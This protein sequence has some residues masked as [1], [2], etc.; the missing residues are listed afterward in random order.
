MAEYTQDSAPI[1]VETPLGKDKLLLEA[2]HGT[3]ALGRLF[4]FELDM[5][6]PEE[7]IDP[8]KI[9][10]KKVSFR[11]NDGAGSPRWFTGFVS[12]FTRI[13]QGKRLSRWRAE[14]VP[15]L[16]F[17]TRTSDCRIWQQK[18][19]PEILQ[20]VLGDH[21]SRVSVQS[22]I[23]MTHTPWEYCVQYRETD[24]AFVSR[25]MEQEGIT[26]FFR[27][28]H[29]D[30]QTVL[31]DCPAAWAECRDGKV[32]GV[33][34]FASTSRPG[35]LFAW[36]R[37]WSYRSGAYAERDYH[38]ETPTTDLLVTAKGKLGFESASDF[39]LYE[40][41]GEYEKKGDGQ[42]WAK[43]RMEE[44]EVP[45]DVIEG[46]SSCRS[47]SPGFLFK[48]ADAK[49]YLLTAV[50]HS[51]RITG[52]YGTEEEPEEFEYRNEF[53]AIP[54]EVPFR[55]ARTTPKPL[56]S[57]AQ[58][59]IVVG[60]PGEE[61]YPDKYGRVKVQFYWD[62]YG[63]NDDKSSCWIR[64]SQPHAG[65]GWGHIDLPRIGEEVIVSFYEGDPDRPIITGR[66]Y[67]ARNMP[68]FSLP[69][70]MTRTGIKSKTHKGG[71]YNEISVDDTAGKEQIRIHGQYDMNTVVENDE[72]HTIHNN[73]T[74]NIDVDETMTIGN[75]QKL[76]VG[77]NKTVS[78]GA[79]HTETVGANQSTSVGSNQTN[80]V[81]MMR[82]HS[83]GINE[84]INVGAAQEITV[85]AFQA[86]S[87]G[88][89][90]TISV[91]AAQMVSVGMSQT[92]T[93]GTS[94]TFSIGTSMSVDAGDQILL[95]TGA[96]S[97]LMKKDGTITIQGKDVIIKATG[98]ITAKAAGD[99]VLK[100]AKIGQN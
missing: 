15:G 39:E 5:L 26:Y 53:T 17:L 52:A 49:K 55:T 78:V 33:S 75:N 42:S 21:S 6:S 74:K 76:D 73:R 45:A 70:E 90:Q 61:I 85:G 51:A 65:S 9:V 29:N 94:A 97:L 68:P 48:D 91:G 47:F 66:V 38:F 64:V 58:P 95:K 93:V 71:G 43:V 32:E 40:Y 87:V 22:K 41:P 31:T 14:V 69:G 72:T 30:L 54:A 18:S 59:A 1:A 96:A 80:T 36:T 50:S 77:V 20:A 62:R 86:I 34:T 92:T 10:G 44:E 16:W 99:M 23:E 81:A 12:R 82:T 11:V 79:N 63:K 57:G 19:V 56:I 4:R 98:K 35:L 13:G 8:R 88:G 100:A 67:N 3:E 89:L 27:H 24:F 83:V 46:R 28:D 60:P 25:L 37:A 84:M 2:F 7:R